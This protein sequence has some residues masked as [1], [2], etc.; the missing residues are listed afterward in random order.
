MVRIQNYEYIQ[1]NPQNNFF[2][3]FLNG[4]LQ[5]CV[6]L[7]QT[8]LSGLFE[9]LVRLKIFIVSNKKEAH[10]TEQVALLSTPPGSFPNFTS[11]Q[12]YISS[13][14]MIPLLAKSSAH[15]SVSFYLICSLFLVP[16]SPSVWNNVRHCLLL[17]AHVHLTQGKLA[18]IRLCVTETE[19]LQGHTFTHL[20]TISCLNEAEETFV[21]W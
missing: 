11:Q 16:E 8:K 2:F 13:E 20:G 3:F 12:H 4:T 10:L 1:L 6:Q 17:C 19:T 21:S 18:V 15:I 14:T 7:F 9:H 5:I